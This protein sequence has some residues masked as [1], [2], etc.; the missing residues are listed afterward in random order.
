V[1]E[2]GSGEEAVDVVDD[3]APVHDL[4]EDVLSSMR[5]EV[6]GWWVRGWRL[7]AVVYIK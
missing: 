5:M 6:S 3:V 4:P 7:C 2:V 1:V